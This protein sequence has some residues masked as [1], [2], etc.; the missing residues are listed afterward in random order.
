MSR[1]N[2]YLRK[3]GKVLICGLILSLLL[4]LAISSQLLATG[5]QGDPEP[6]PPVGIPG[7]GVPPTAPGDEGEGATSFFLTTGPQGDPEP[8]PPVGI[9]WS[10]EDPPTAPGDEDDE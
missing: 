5:P 10:Q 1:P 3:Y 9:P 7:S 2:T 6:A 8:A 4:V